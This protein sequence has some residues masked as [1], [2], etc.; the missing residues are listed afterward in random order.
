MKIL[1]GDSFSISMYPMEALGFGNSEQILEEVGVF[2]S[3]EFSKTVIP[4]ILGGME[5]GIMLV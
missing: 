5:T 3:M 2:S 4:P 1:C